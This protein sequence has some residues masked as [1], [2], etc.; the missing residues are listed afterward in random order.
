MAYST[1]LA[2]LRSE[3]DAQRVLK[4]AT[5]L[6]SRFESH[7]IG[8]HSEPTVSLTYASPLD[9]PDP[10]VYEANETVT[11]ERMSTIHTYFEEECEKQGLSSEWRPIHS[12][13]GDSATSAIS[14]ARCADLVIVQQESPGH[15]ENYDDLESLVFSGGRPVLFVPYIQADAKPIRQ[16]LIA[17]ND[18]REAAR[19]VFDAIP[20]LK[21]ADAV[22][23]M[24]VDADNNDQQSATVAG[25]EIA[26]TLARHGINVTINNQ[27]SA[28]IPVSAVI[29]NRCSDIQADL[30]VMGA[31]S[32]SRLREFLFGGVTDT[33]LKSMPCLTLMSK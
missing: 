1:I 22:E 32:H 19:A 27:P 24:T 23:I 17:W 30:L 3:H 11:R 33:V 20:F 15:E 28:G 16:V 25:A 29:E 7:L 26:A 6:A 8:L 9:V 5:A 31:F 2:V 12:A 14:S 4:Q 18:T 21:S 10:N 13:S